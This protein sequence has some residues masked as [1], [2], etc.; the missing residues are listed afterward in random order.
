[1]L[2]KNLIVAIDFDDVC[3]DFNSMFAEYN[4]VHH[5]TSYT[6]EDIQDFDLSKLLKC[7]QEE[8]LQRA[9]EFVHSELHTMTQ[10]ILGAVEALAHLR[11]QGA[12]L[13]V[14]TARDKVI[15]TPTTHLIKKHFSP[16]FHGV[17]FLHE[18]YQKVMGEKGDVCARLCA[19][20]LIEDAL[21][22]ALHFSMKTT[23]VLLFD[24]PWNQRED[25]PEHVTR[26]FG[27][28]HALEIIEK[29]P[30]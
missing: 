4:R 18:N 2:E 26:T 21:H 16:G 30:R 8:A 29:W 20:F 28:N 1:M 24:T 5:G 22:N 10:P 7:S 13:H 12:E 9:L 15:E 25:L 27:W 23:Q 6:R 17:H 19:D 14:V 11:T 3:V